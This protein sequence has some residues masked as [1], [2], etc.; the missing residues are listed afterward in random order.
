VTERE[1]LAIQHL[2]SAGELTPGQLSARLQLSSGGTTG[3]IHRMLRAG[4]I[5]R[6]PHTRDGRTAVLCL[7]P[8]IQTDISN[9]LTPLVA[10]LDSLV[11]ALPD[12]EA[13]LIGCFLR[14][15]ANAAQRHAAR[16]AADA[17]A[18]AQSALAVRLPALWA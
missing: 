4:H 12:A 14:D 9:A 3:L 5:K 8:E 13:Q 1:V 16:L 2:A 17:D 11:D 7:T 10:Q 6:I 15:V 18:S